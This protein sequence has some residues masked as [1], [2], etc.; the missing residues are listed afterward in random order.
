MKKAI[1]ILILAIF[2]INTVFAVTENDP[3]PTTKPYYFVFSYQ[4]P[5]QTTPN[6][7]SYASNQPLWLYDV[8]WSFAAG[9]FDGSDTPMEYYQWRA[10]LNRWNFVTNY[11]RAEVYLEKSNF[12]ILHTD[13]DM[14]NKTTG[15]SVVPKE[16]PTS[17]EI[18]SP[19]NGFVDTGNTMAWTVLV[20]GVT[21]GEFEVTAV[22]DTIPDFNS[23]KEVTSTWTTN[24]GTSHWASYAAYTIP[25]G[26]HTIKCQLKKAGVVLKEASFNF[27]LVTGLVD[28]NGDGKDDRTNLPIEWGD[29]TYTPPSTSGSLP[30]R[31]TYS[32]DILGTVAWG[33]DT[34]V[35]IVSTPF[36]YF[37]KFVKLLAENA[38]TLFT[39]FGDFSRFVGEL[40]KWMPPPLFTLVMSI[41]GILGGLT[42][43]KVAKS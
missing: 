4:M 28:E 13:Y 36:I 20:K 24:E 43:W 14:K 40:F 2:S 17:I 35:A 32:N 10:D 8:G 21:A 41:V 12:K 7:F 18:T 9:T 27:E 29:N 31:A 5:G 1:I 3:P 38:K 42:I 11:N 22:S 30:D 25:P 16:I 39:S 33:F 19:R 6:I 23:K 34:L 26:K 15:E 37:G